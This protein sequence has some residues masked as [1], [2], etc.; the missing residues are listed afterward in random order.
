VDGDSET[1]L[2]A[3][4]IKQPNG[5][6]I[7]DGRLLLGIS[8]DHSIK[9][10]D[11]ET[12]QISTLARFRTGIMDGL[13]ADGDGNILFSHWQGRV[14]R[15]G[16]SGSPQLVLDTTA[17]ETKCADFEYVPNKRLLIVPTFEDGTVTAYRL[18]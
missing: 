5:L 7:H 2:P 11:L 8:S 10:V 15:L 9:S 1:W 18:P 6:W 16:G 13:K 12:K 17:S 3:G 4:R 14:Y